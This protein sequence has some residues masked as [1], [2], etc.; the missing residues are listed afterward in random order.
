[1]KDVVNVGV[2]LA[3]GLSTRMTALKQLIP[4]DGKPMVVKSS[5]NLIDGGADAVVV[6]GGFSSDRVKRVLDFYLK[7]YGDK[8]FFTV[9]EDYKRGEMFSSVKCG[10]S[11]VFKHFL[12]FKSVF[13]YPVDYPF[14]RGSTIKEMLTAFNRAKADVVIP[15]FD[16]KKGH[17]V[18]LSRRCCS[19][20]CRG[21]S[22]N[23][24]LKDILNSF[25]S[26]TLFVKVNDKAILYDIDDIASF[27]R[28]RRILS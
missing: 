19:A 17:P 2:V 27:V 25:S 11:F 14:V 26:T 12:S 10:I 24:T 5:L 16:G 15:V 7:R 23:T 9:N 6:V 3:A 4:I 28:V 21:F 18:L 1:M 22:Y 20:V 13:V 8:I